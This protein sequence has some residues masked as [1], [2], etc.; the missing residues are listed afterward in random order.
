MSSLAIALHARSYRVQAARKPALSTPT[1]LHQVL[2]GIG[3]WT[4]CNQLALILD[5]DLYQWPL[6]AISVN[7]LHE[8]IGWQ[9]FLAG[10]KSP[11]LQ[12]FRLTAILLKDS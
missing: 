12:C 7:I 5:L 9:G 11:S 2:Y 6:L 4:H 1:T 8:D 3:H 10:M